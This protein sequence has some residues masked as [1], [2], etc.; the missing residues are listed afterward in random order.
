MF[1]TKSIFGFINVLNSN[2][3]NGKR[4]KEDATHP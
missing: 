2:K 4:E 1:L 3:E